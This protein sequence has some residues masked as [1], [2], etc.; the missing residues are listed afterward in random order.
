MALMS[1]DSFV[2]KC[3]HAFSA[4]CFISWLPPSQTGHPINQIQY[5]QS[6]YLHYLLYCEQEQ[7]H[8]ILNIYKGKGVKSMLLV[9]LLIEKTQS[10][11]CSLRQSNV[12]DFLHIIL[13]A[14]HKHRILYIL[15][16]RTTLSASLDCTYVYNNWIFSTTGA[17]KCLPCLKIQGNWPHRSS[18]SE[19]T[20]E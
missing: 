6:K 18:L 20:T 11:G 8:T 5:D 12:G 3:K 1:S 15:N 16:D 13:T 4:H 7:R 2:C 14:S 19:T 17:L 9:I 10:S